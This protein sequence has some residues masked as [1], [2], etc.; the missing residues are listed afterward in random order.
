M[1]NDSRLNVIGTGFVEVM[2]MGQRLQA[3]FLA[4]ESTAEP[5]PWAGFLSDPDDLAAFARREA[6]RYMQS[7]T[8]ARPLIQLLSHKFGG[9]IALM[10]MPETRKEQ[11]AIASV[12]RVVLATS[13]VKA[14]WMVYEAWMATAH[15]GAPD[16]HVPPSER[17]DRREVAVV[18]S[19]TP[20]SFRIICHGI[21]RDAAGKVTDLPEPVEMEGG[22]WTANNLMM[23]NLFDSVEKIAALHASLDRGSGR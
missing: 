13:P 21:T 4:N 22:E 10:Q 19:A 9:M 23:G 2:R 5:A 7:V 3:A 11:A 16:E 12:L 1:Q 18:I 6:L 17:P 20:Q 15:R 8:Q 14:Y